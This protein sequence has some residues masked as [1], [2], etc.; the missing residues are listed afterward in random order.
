MSSLSS[1]SSCIALLFLSET[2]PFSLRILSVEATFVLTFFG[3]VVSCSSSCRAKMA[4]CSVS[5]LFTL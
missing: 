2:S 3:V 5:M 1:S 4:C